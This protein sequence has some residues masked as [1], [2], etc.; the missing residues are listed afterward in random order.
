MKQVKHQ[1]LSGHP[2]IAQ[3]LLTL[4]PQ[5]VF[6]QVVLQEDSDRYYKRPRTKDH[7]ICMF[8][9]VLT[10]N[11]S[12]REVCKNIALIITKLIPFGMN[13]LPA[14]STLSDTN[15][16]RSHKVLEQL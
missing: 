11:S 14:R 9:A 2:I 5:G 4:I 13:Q 10:K 15:R 8:Y 16:K 12:L 7:F 6:D 3:L 1:F